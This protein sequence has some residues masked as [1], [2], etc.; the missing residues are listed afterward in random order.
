MEAMVFKIK[1][2]AEEYQRQKKKEIRERM[3][4]IFEFKKN[5]MF[6]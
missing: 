2:E 1:E 4:Q 3:H 6:N 5:L